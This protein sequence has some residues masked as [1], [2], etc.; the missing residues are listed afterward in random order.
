[1]SLS[2]MNAVHALPGGASGS[3]FASRKYLESKIED[4]R[5]TKKTRHVTTHH[6]SVT[7]A[8]THRSVGQII[9]SYNN[10]REFCGFTF[11]FFYIKV[12]NYVYWFALALEVQRI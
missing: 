11:L 8:V 6:H 2:T 7:S 12:M 3:V 1:M 9:P 5:V 4:R 10:S